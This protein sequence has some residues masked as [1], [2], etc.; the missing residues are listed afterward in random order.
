M[1]CIRA[2]LFVA[3]AA[4]SC[5][6]EAQH[7][8]AA[9]RP[10]TSP[11]P[12]ARQ[13]DFLIGQWELDVHP[14]VNSLAAMIHGAPQLTGTWKAW[15]ALDGFGID[16]ETR[17]VDSSGNPLSL[18][19]AMRVYGGVEGHWTVT[20][21]DVYRGRVAESSGQLQGSDIVLSGKGADPEGKPLLT[22]ARFSAIKADSFHLQQDRSADDGA[23]WDE[24][25]LVIDARRVAATAPR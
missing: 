4:S 11:P 12:E 14:K 24:G 1:N 8:G 13:F 17:I 18:S 6:A 3:A 7:S 25:V 10:P 5:G 9:Q 19:H 16:D 20:S 21:I 23:T 22:R 15:R 2:L